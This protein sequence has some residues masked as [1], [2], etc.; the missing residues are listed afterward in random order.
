ML[1]LGTFVLVCIA[2]PV[3]IP[4]FVPLVFLFY[5]IRSRYIVASRGCKRWEAVSRSPVYAF[6]T[7]SIKGLPTIR[8]FSAGNRFDREFLDLLSLNN[9]WCQ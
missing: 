1:V 2:V 5:Y 4:V 9:S 3:M 6:F 7:Q 8:A